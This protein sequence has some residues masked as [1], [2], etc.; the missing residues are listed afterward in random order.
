M[1]HT[2]R[3]GSAVNRGFT[4]VEVLVVAAVV[5]LSLLL[6]V[7]GLLESRQAAQREQCVNNLKRLGLALHNYHDVHARFPPGWVARGQ[8]PIGKH[9]NGWQAGLLPY[10]DQVP[11]YNKLDTVN[12]EVEFSDGSQ[13]HSLQELLKTPVAAYQCPAE[14]ESAVNSLRGGW[15]RSNY[16]GNYGATPIPRWTD[17]DFLPGQ[18]P[19][20]MGRNFR[21]SG[22]LW[23]NSS[24]RIRDITDGT[25]NT[26]MVGEKSVVSRAGLWMGVRS[27]YH[28]SDTVSDGSWASGMNATDTGFSSRHRGGIN[29]GLCDGSVRF[30][31]DT[32][33]SS[34]QGSVFQALSTC[35]G[36]EVIGRF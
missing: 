34:P 23:E 17:L 7:P 10:I 11:L 1:S 18:I 14:P 26:L 15:G 27:S 36:G 33:A 20:P 28:E 29:F 19:A 16:S 35:N 6:A 5:M 4:I 8:R 9:S 24:R 30:I 3:T 12:F 31:A 2:N 25:S 22:I 13:N 21:S 32:V